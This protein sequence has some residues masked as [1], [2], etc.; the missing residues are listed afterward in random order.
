MAN[1][2]RVYPKK[3]HKQSLALQLF[4]DF[5]GTSACELIDLLDGIAS[6]EAKVAI[7]TDGLKTVNDFGLNVFLPGM[8][9]LTRKWIDIEVTGKFSKVFMD[10]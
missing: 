3:K 8:N 7:D 6:Q 2:F 5:D 1:N 10:T 9:R 4:G